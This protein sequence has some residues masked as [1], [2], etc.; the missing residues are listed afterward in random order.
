MTRLRPLTCILAVVL[1]ALSCSRAPVDTSVTNEA[2]G[3]HFASVPEGFD[4]VTNEGS[5]LELAPSGEDSTGRMRFIVGPEQ[6]SINLVASLQADRARLEAMPQGDYKGGQE[7]QGP[8][9]PAFYS[10]G[11]YET[12]GATVEE[13]RIFSIH[14]SSMRLLTL[15]YTYPAGADSAQRVTELIGVFAEVEAISGAQ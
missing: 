15:S 7:L 2:L 12:D 6:H 4:V 8:S 14:P 13:T 5:M 1:A 3:L 9:G 11:R 10:R